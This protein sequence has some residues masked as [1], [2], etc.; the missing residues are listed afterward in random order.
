MAA[1]Q[2]HVREEQLLAVQLHVVGDA[3]VPDVTAGTGGADGLHHRLLGA[4][5]ARQISQVLS[6]A[7]N[8]LTTN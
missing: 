1:V 8:K 4:E 6:E 2:V 5:P 3:D 7:K